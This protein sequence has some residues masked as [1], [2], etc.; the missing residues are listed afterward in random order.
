MQEAL[1]LVREDWLADDDVLHRLVDVVDKAEHAS[2]RVIE[3]VSEM[4][5]EKHHNQ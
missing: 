1:K 3:Y 4:V 5:R 2:N